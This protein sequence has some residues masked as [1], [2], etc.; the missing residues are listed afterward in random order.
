MKKCSRCKQDKTVDNYSKN[1]KAKDRLQSNC[2]Q[3]ATEAAREWYKR[4]INKPEVHDRL[5][6]YYR[7]K[8][9]EFKNIVDDLKI[10][11]GCLKCGE[12]A[13]C[14]LDF[15]HVKGDKNKEISWLIKTKNKQALILELIKCVC[16]CANC[17]RKLHA[18]I[19][20]LSNDE[21]EYAIAKMELLLKNMGL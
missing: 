16:V 17:H 11:F 8:Q 21:I 14:C 13:L 9:R 5:C 1:E 4:N 10:E 15:H 2:K 7:D 20:I 6:A 12:T 3:C 18:G 19:V